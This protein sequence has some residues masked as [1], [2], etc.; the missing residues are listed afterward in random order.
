VQACLAQI[1]AAGAELIAIT[2]SRPQDLSRHLEAEPRPFPFVCDPDRHTFRT[3]G[4]ERGTHAMLLKP[5]V[6][7]H[8]LR[9]LFGGWRVRPVAKG[10]DVLQLG[11]DVVLD[12]DH[13]IVFLHRSRTPPDRPDPETLIRPSAQKP[14][15]ERMPRVRPDRRSR[16]H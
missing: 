2:Q 1:R 5:R 6:I 13:R 15:A 12:R 8:Y 14:I 16:M 10:E 4:L 3:F 11:G 7:G 9:R